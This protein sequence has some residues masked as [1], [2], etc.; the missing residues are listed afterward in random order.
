MNASTTDYKKNID[1]GYDTLC[2]ISI[3]CK[4]LNTENERTLKK[5][6]TY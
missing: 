6:K 2:V 5:A 4:A 1:C 3:C